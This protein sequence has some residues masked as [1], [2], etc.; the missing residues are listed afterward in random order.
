MILVTYNLYFHNLE[1]KLLYKIRISLSVILKS[2]KRI[3]KAKNLYIYNGH[4]DF[5]LMIIALPLYS[6]E[7]YC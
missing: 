2:I 3:K 7:P 6:K 4:T 5:L 1:A